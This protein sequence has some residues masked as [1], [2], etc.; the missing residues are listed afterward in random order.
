[1]SEH[2]SLTLKE[3]RKNET[4][5]GRQSKLKTKIEELGGATER[6]VTHGTPRVLL[7]GQ[8][9]CRNFSL[10]IYIYSTAKWTNIHECTP[11]WPNRLLSRVKYEKH[12]RHEANSFLTSNFLRLLHWLSIDILSIYLNKVIRYQCQFLARYQQYITITK[13]IANCGCSLIR[14]SLYPIVVNALSRMRSCTSYDIGNVCIYIY[15]CENTVDT[16]YLATDRTTT[17]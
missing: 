13:R 1:M 3:E 11:N 9:V 2:T 12:P 5:R 6:S 16:D 17:N 8:R 7:R 14:L 10:N 15:I 4:K